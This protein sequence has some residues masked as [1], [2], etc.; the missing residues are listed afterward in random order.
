[1]A[2]ISNA[3]RMEGSSQVPP[4]EAWK[5]RKRR[6]LQ[7]FAAKLIY[8][9]QFHWLYWRYLRQYTEPND[10][11]LKHHLFW[12]AE[13]FWSHICGSDEIALEYLVRTFVPSYRSKKW[14][15]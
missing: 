3:P 7:R 5:G 12:L 1:M 14:R 6:Q 10:L 2:E 15:N 9:E 11:P 8:G 13:G 4:F